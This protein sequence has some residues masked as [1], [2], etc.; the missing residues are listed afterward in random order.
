MKQ[1]APNYHSG[2]IA[3]L[4]APL[5]VSWSDGVLVRLRELPS[6]A[7]SLERAADGIRMRA[8]VWLPDFGARWR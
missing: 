1:I 6:K 8:Y 5:P 7:K 2:E 4:E 3:L